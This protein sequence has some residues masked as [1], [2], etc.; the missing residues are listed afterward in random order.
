MP[1]IL[2]IIY[3]RAAGGVRHELLTGAGFDVVT[4]NDNFEAKEACEQNR[5][6]AIIVG[7]GSPLPERKSMVDWLRNHCPGVPIISLHSPRFLPVREAD[8]S[9]DGTNTA[10]VVTTLR[11]V[12]GS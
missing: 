8:Y 7:Y 3:D 2:H 6:K 5:F 4:V 12:V 10:A 1:R 11:N 9:I